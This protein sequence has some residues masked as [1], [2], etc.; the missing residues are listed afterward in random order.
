[1]AEPFLSEET[2]DEEQYLCTV[3]T[4]S[5][6]YV[7]VSEDSPYYIAYADLV[8][9]EGS[10][11]SC[12]QAFCVYESNNSS[13]ETMISQKDPVYENQFIEE[14]HVILI[15]EEENSDSESDSDE[16]SHPYIDIDEEIKFQTQKCRTNTF[17]E[18]P[19]ENAYPAST[20]STKSR[21]PSKL[22]CTGMT[23]LDDHRVVIVTYDG[24]I[25]LFGDSGSFLSLRNFEEHFEDVTALPDSCIAATCGFC[26][27]VYKVKESDVSELTDKCFDFECNSFMTVHGID[28][29]QREFVVSC[30][31]QSINPSPIICMLDKK[32][33]IKK[34]FKIPG[35][36]SPRYVVCS[37]DKKHIFI[38]DPMMKTVFAL[39]WDGKI[40]WKKEDE[41]IPTSLTTLP[42]HTLAVACHESLSFK[43][44]SYEGTLKRIIH[45]EFAEISSSVLLSYHTHSGLLL[46]CPEL[47]VVGKRDFIYFLKVKSTKKN[48]FASML[49]LL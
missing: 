34:T 38:A 26:V 15:S 24:E 18:G 35:L 27:R 32:G 17:G 6:D 49:S 11:N 1:M 19:H 41:D 29:I 22:T 25:L 16:N 33:R 42:G 44:Y 5:N 46:F 23:V 14:E 30:N 3:K 40:K 10:L 8:F 43:L 9:N 36:I 48:I 13:N 12:H 28:Y 4:E 45:A 37:L 47:H 21:Q 39:T 20:P 7:N 31:L 2:Q